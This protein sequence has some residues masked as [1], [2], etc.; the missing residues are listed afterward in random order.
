MQAL[1][2]IMN[3]LI[4]TTKHVDVVKLKTYFLFADV[5]IAFNFR[6]QRAKNID[7]FQRETM[8]TEI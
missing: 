7:M 1:E 3:A 8:S 4:S 2:D 6:R 5:L